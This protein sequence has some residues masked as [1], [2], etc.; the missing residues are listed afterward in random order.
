[1]ARYNS[2]ALSPGHRCFGPT[3][4]VATD[5]NASERTRT[6]RRAALALGEQCSETVDPTMVAC[7]RRDEQLLDKLLISQVMV[8]TQRSPGCL[9]PLDSDCRHDAP[10]SSMSRRY[11]R[12]SDSGQ[13]E[14]GSRVNLRCLPPQSC[15]GIAAAASSLR[16]TLRTRPAQRAALRA[17]PGSSRRHVGAPAPPPPG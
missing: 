9:V 8:G 1:M 6:F 14:P 4:G 16:P 3:A 5:P 7:H 11:T 10:P 12:L 17:I 2:A 15:R 13:S